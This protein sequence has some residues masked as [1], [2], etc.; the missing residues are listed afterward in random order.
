[1]SSRPATAAPTR[2]EDGSWAPA[3]PDARLTQYLCGAGDGDSPRLTM[4][5]R[6]VHQ[7]LGMQRHGRSADGRDTAYTL[8]YC[9]PAGSLSPRSGALD[10]PGY[11]PSRHNAISQIKPADVSAPATP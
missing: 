7:R 1:V 10:A 3:A 2:R 4:F 8:S 5:T 11:H 6:T 9:Q